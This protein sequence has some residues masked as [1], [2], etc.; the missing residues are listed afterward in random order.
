MKNLP[1]TV[2]QLALCTLFVV[3]TSVAFAEVPKMTSFKFELQ[4]NTGKILNNIVAD[5]YGD[6]LIV[7]IIPRQQ[8]AFDLKATF[9][10]AVAVPVTVNGVEQ[11]STITVNDF[12]SPVSYVITSG[13]D[14]RTYKVKLVYTG[15]P[16][17]YVHTDGE[18]PIASK[19]DYV[20]GTIRIYSNEEG[21]ETLDTP[22]GIR[23]RGNSTWMMDKKPY[24]IKLGTAASVLG[25]PSDKDWVL[26]ANYADKTLMRTSLAFDL[27]YQMNLAWTPKM[28]HVDLVVN[29]VYQGNYLIGEH[30][31]VDKDRVNIKELDETDTDPEKINGGYF[32]EVDNYRD[33]V[34]FLL[35]SELPV[36][37]KS[38]DEPTEQQY[39]FAQN[40]MQQTEDA[41]NAPNFADPEEGY[42]KYLD[43]ETFIEYYWVQEIFKNLDAQDGSSI[44]Y[45][46][47]R[48]KKLN[49]GPLWD[50]DVSAGNVDINGANDPTGFYIRESKWFKRLFEDPAF[51]NATNARWVTLRQS[52]LAN[53]STVI[54]E[55]S[56][57]LNVSQT[58]NFHK[59]DIL[60]KIVYPS[61]HNFGSYKGE[62]DYLKDWLLTR[63][64]WIDA[65]TEQPE[66]APF[67]LKKP[68]DEARFVVTPSEINE[69][70]FSWEPSTQGSSYRVYFDKIDGDFSNSIASFDVN[71]SPNDTTATISHSQLF[72]LF[73]LVDEKDSVMLKWTA[74]A[75]LG[76]SVITANE[77]HTIK[78]VN[79]LIGV[80]QLHSPETSA[81][82]DGITPTLKWYKAYLAQTYDLQVSTTDDF[83]TSAVNR[84]GLTDTTYL[85]TEILTDQT[86]YYWRAR[87]VNATSTSEWSE[88]RSFTTPLISGFGESAVKIAMYPNPT[89]RELFIELPPVTHIENAELVDALG[90]TAVSLDLAPG[91]TTKV[92]VSTLQRG[93][94]IMIL[95]GGFNKPVTNRIV[96]R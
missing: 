5:I 77:A 75:T 51:K 64:A 16:L 7:G 33:G 2:R 91:A 27:G 89:S 4:Y 74:Q 78:L 58:E 54:D 86:T 69:I 18:A 43:K 12:S 53:L 94:Y 20:N 28:T 24:R 80:P 50:F 81:T 34:H 23:G 36:V 55:Y 35:N 46:K 39:G 45:Y 31:K 52:L 3:L 63:I 9:S 82:L 21:V 56:T 6:T 61:P 88:T 48:D 25:M 84:I 72:N 1:S 8:T 68:V 30:V 29:G 79:A 44:Y 57:K 90:R 70:T 38:P 83:S 10:T 17:V 65:N 47:D 96:L 73:T 42:A 66:L 32:L 87:A 19:D 15:L 59:W 76:Q 41:I 93:M 11:Q 95:R 62:V 60:N 26:L 49:M 67:A 71:V 85:V 14:T 40:Y 92:D 37:F 22:L 13:T